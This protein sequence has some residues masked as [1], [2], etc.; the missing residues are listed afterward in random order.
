MNKIYDYQVNF[1]LQVEKSWTTRMMERKCSKK[2]QREQMMDGFIKRLITR[3]LG[4]I[5][6]TK[7]IRKMWKTMI[8]NAT[9]H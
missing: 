1:L 2:K 8:P 7:K 5:L 4:E 3:Q 9:Q 6:D